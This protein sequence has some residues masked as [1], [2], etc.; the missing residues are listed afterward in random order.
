MDFIDFQAILLFV[1]HKQKYKVV[2]ILA[3]LP[4]LDTAVNQMVNLGVQTETSMDHFQV[5]I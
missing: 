4:H 2:R 5:A 1:Q 3:Y